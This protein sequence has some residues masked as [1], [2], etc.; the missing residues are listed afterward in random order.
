MLRGVLL[1]DERWLGSIHGHDHALASLVDGHGGAVS[2]EDLERSVV[3]L[4]ER[5]PD[6]IVAQ[7][8]ESA[9]GQI[10]WN[11]GIRLVVVLGGHRTKFL[12]DPTQILH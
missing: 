10:L 6:C 3:R 2:F 9:G 12:E 5:L 4:L 7:E 11:V 8:D 1:V